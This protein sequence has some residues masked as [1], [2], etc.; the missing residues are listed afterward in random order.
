MKVEQH[1]I[2]AEVT[3]PEGQ[4][5]DGAP[6][7]FD[8]TFA[9]DTP[10]RRYDWENSRYFDEVLD[11]TPKAIDASRLNAGLPLLDS[12]NSWS[13][14]SVLGR[15]ISWSIEGGKA[16]ARVRLSNRDDVAGIRKDIEDGILADISVGY[17]VNEYKQEN[18][19]PGTN[20][21]PVY[22]AVS[23]QPKEISLVPVPADPRS[24]VGR[25]DKDAP[26]TFP[27]T[28]TSEEIRM[29]PKINHPEGDE[30]Q[31]VTEQ[32]ANTPA[33]VDVAAVRAAER[34][35]L[36][37]I[38]SIAKT[39]N[40]SDEFVA[41]HEDAGSTIEAVR[42]DALA[43]LERRQPNLNSANPT[44]SG[45]RDLEH[46]RFIEVAT[47]GVVLRSGE[48]KN[49][50][51]EFRKDR[52]LYNEAQTYRGMKLSRLA[53]TC[54]RRTGVDTSRMSDEEIIGRSIT[55][56]SS[57]FPVLLEG[58]NRRILLAAYQATPD[59][60]RQFCATGSVTDFRDHWRL[61]DG[62][63]GDLLKVGENGE[64]KTLAIGDA[65]REKIAVETFGNIINVSRK[66][67]VNDDL[68]AFT[69]LA[70]KLGRSAARTI[71]KAVYTLLTS[72]SGVGPTMNDG[73]ALF[74]ADHGNIYGTPSAPTVAVFEAMRVQMAQ[75]MDVNENDYLDIRPDLG[76]FPMSI[77]G[78]ARILNGSQYDPDAV[79][80][81]QKPN[82]VNG[83]LSNIIDTPRLSGTRYY[84][85]AD[86]AQNPVLEV[87]FL[88]GVQTP[89]L[90]SEEAFTQDGMKWK[91][92]HDFGVA[93]VG[94]RGAITNAGA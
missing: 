27:V 56:N 84:M 35:R 94:W 40:L 92:R 89:F 17:R 86:P 1:Y 59:T 71:E 49:A 31:P 53:E 79:N 88:N 90:D 69:S 7:E 5:A 33:P 38:R 32:R 51:A 16:K 82:L 44:V 50:E 36:S 83:L 9:T 63:L 45:G 43:E 3:M 41:R 15:S 66:M 4:R 60:W 81:L 46:E 74:H 76:L 19:K 13:L 61:R 24:G 77:A 67:I 78:S 39:H 93:A 62:S 2:R 6:F 26:E 75:Q 47:A 48:D 11:I 30:Q 73:K 21:I 34:K 85:F 8:V 18:V 52:E 28:V 68:G 37:E 23:W 80:K 25:S 72:N 42:L 70:S 12:H 65:E 91:I 57:D 20:E 55:S 58:T 54:L 10:V 14:E 22:R 87:A 64:Y 29:D